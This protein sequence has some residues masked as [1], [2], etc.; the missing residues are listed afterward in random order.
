MENTTLDIKY[1]K[2]KNHPRIF[3]RSNDREN[4]K[5][6]NT[7]HI[8]RQNQNEM[9]VTIITKEM[10]WDQNLFLSLNI[11]HTWRVWIDITNLCRIIQKAKYYDVTRSCLY[12]SYKEMIVVNFQIM[13]ILVAVSKKGDK[14]PMYDFRLYRF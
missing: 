5:T 14:L 3:R 13:Y 1:W 2:K 8:F 6:R 11:I 7:L 10:F 4:R 12:I 9:C